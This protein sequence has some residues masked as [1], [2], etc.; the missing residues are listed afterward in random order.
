MNSDTAEQE[1]NG[2]S[3]P[4]PAAITLAAPSLR[5]ASSVRVLSGEKKLRTTPMPNTTR[6]KSMSTFGVS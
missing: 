5:P 6:L 2:V 3:T 1:Q 4:R